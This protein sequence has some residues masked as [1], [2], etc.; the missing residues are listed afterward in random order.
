MSTHDVASSAPD[1]TRNASDPSDKHQPRH[2]GTTD[3]EWGRSD[4]PDPDDVGDIADEGVAHR[5]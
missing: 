1:D 2:P 3:D 4:N 5:G